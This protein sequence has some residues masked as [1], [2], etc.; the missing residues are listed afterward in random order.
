[1]AFSRSEYKGVTSPDVGNNWERTAK[2]NKGVEPGC[3]RP[4]EI[5]PGVPGSPV[6]ETKSM[7]NRTWAIDQVK[8]ARCFSTNASSVIGGRPPSFSTRSLVPAKTPF[9]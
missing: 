9:W 4:R 2:R 7:V 3:R 5:H 8:A 1:M 6:K